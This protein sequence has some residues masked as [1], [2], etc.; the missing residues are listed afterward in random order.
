MS[1]LPS[2]PFLVERYIADTR[3]LSLEEHGAYLL[4]LFNMWQRE[5]FLPDIDADNA[6]LLGVPVKQWLKLKERLAPFL[7]AANGTLT[8]NRLQHQWNRAIDNRNKAAV[9]GRKGGLAFAETC[10]VLSNVKQSKARAP[11]LAKPEQTAERPLDQPS[12]LGQSE[13]KSIHISKNNLTT[14]QEDRGAEE[15][16]TSIRRLLKTNLMRTGTAKVG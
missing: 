14:S 9:N 5:G 1:K 15:D 10:R 8:Q 6:R 7:I 4:L 16:F 2:M 3:H 13:T 12:E 11:A